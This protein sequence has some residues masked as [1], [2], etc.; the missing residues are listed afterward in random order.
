MIRAR[1]QA[2]LDAVVGEQQLPGAVAAAGSSDGVV[3]VASGFADRELH[4]PMREDSILLS[5]SIGKSFVAAL[6]LLL[7]QENVLRL[8]DRVA[9]WLGDLAWYARLPNGR[10]ITLRQLLNHG[11]GIPDHIYEPECA[12]WRR[13]RIHIPDAALT[14]EEMIGFILDKPPLFEPGKGF[15]YSDTAYI[16]AGLVLERAGG[17][18]Y[19]DLL[20]RRFLGPLELN[21]TRPSNERRIPGLASG[22]LLEG[23]PFG[24]GPDW[25]EKVVVDGSLIFNPASEWTGGGLAT[26]PRDLVRWSLA[27]YRGKALAEPYLDEL[28]TV[29]ADVESARKRVGGAYALGAIVRETEFGAAY[30][31]TGGMPGYTGSMAYFPAHDLALALQVNQNQCRLAQAESALVAAALGR[32][33][34]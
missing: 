10:E 6:A 2:A 27:L 4:A 12:E 7:Q 29:N 8:D 5:A 33:E 20:Q 15:A 14:P 17:S 3:V 23:G 18:R 21:R 16:L 32:S 26:N 30:G 31:H 1:L 34:P 25:P 11:S 22:Y 13:Q 19:Y 28:L 9:R 24:R